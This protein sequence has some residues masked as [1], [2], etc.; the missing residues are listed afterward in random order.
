MSENATLKEVMAY[1]SMS[2]S[3]FTPEWRKLTS[4]DKEDLRKGIGDS[5]L[6]Y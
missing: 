3:E 4:Q 2:P 1:F 5:S 6:S